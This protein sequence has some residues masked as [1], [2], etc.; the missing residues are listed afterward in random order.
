MENTQDHKSPVSIVDLFRDL[1]AQEQAA[2]EYNFKQYVDLVWGIY[3]RCCREDP[4]LLT[5]QLKIANVKKPRNQ[6]G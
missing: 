6:T 1:T 2:A 5:E 4:G 3:E